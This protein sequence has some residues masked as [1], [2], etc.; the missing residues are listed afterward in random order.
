MGAPSPLEL[1]VEEFLARAGRDRPA[2]RHARQR[3][4]WRLTAFAVDAG[5]FWGLFAET[6][7][8][9]GTVDLSALAAGADGPFAFAAATVVGT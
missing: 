3:R 4:P 7:R 9:D 2:T 8:D 6:V 1:S 5:D